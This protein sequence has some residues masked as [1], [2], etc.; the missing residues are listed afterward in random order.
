MD[1][2]AARIVR[3]PSDNRQILPRQLDLRTL[4]DPYVLGFLRRWTF[5]SEKASAQYRD[6]QKKNDSVHFA[7]H[8]I[9]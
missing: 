5:L 1:G 2:V 6:C 3:R 4:D 8:K 7:P 9:I